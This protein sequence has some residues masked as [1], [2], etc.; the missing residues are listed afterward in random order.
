MT[1][2]FDQII[3]LEQFEQAR[4]SI[5]PW[6]ARTWRAKFT[7]WNMRE[8]LFALW[9]Q[10]LPQLGRPWKRHS[11]SYKRVPLGG[12]INVFVRAEPHNA[13]VP[14]K[15]VCMTKSL[16]FHTHRCYCPGGGGMGG[17]NC[18]SRVSLAGSVTCLVMGRRHCRINIIISSVPCQ[19][20]ITKREDYSYTSS[21][22]LPF[23]ECMWASGL[24]VS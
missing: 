19:A 6:H 1:R 2:Q 7:T 5:Q 4:V 16:S 9:R 3:M 22:S 8:K 23:S 20:A 11:N 21:L 24:S 15:I 17:K 14:R 10:R 18:C 13:S 12:P